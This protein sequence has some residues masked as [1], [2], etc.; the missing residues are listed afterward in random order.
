MFLEGPVSGPSILF[1]F[2]DA[3]HLK[4]C[5]KIIFF[6]VCSFLIG[7][8]SFLINPKIREQLRFNIKNL[9]FG[10]QSLQ[11]DFSIYSYLSLEDAELFLEP[12]SWSTR[13]TIPPKKSIAIDVRDIVFSTGFSL[14]DFSSSTGLRINYRF[15]KEKDERF[16]PDNQLFW[17]LVLELE[18][19]SCLRVDFSYL[20]APSKCLNLVINPVRISEPHALV[21]V[22]NTSKQPISFSYLKGYL[23]EEYQKE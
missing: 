22:R 6:I 11:S 12:A 23:Q 7:S 14:Y 17:P 19:S 3:M 8:F 2:F 21:I 10:V 5:Q 4:W 9:N 16:Y 20:V 13:I 15:Y 18:R 1:L